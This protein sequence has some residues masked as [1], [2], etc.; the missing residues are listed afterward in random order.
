MGRGTERKRRKKAGF[1][2]MWLKQSLQRLT[3]DTDLK[4]TGQIVK[5][6]AFEPPLVPAPP[7]SAFVVKA[8]Y[9]YDSSNQLQEER[10]AEPS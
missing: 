2:Q 8:F 10:D 4:E 3:K 1:F 6:K 7:L 9:R 5:G